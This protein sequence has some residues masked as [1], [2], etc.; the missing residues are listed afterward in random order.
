MEAID[1]FTYI[2]ENMPPVLIIHG[3]KD[4]LVSVTGSEAY[5]AKL[6]ELGVKNKLVEIP[7][8]NH[9]TIGNETLLRSFLKVID[10]MSVE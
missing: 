9:G 2:N 5:V 7:F 10:G 4:T 6:S 3:E 1:P 8:C